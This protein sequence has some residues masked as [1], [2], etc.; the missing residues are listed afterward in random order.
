MTTDAAPQP[1]EG[2]WKQRQ[3]NA[4]AGGT[5]DGPETLPKQGT[6]AAARGAG[7]AARE[8]L[9][10]GPFKTQAGVTAVAQGRTTGGWGR[11]E[12]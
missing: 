9:D 5:K 11:W 8:A 2:E 10:A 1:A 7:G 12:R 6:T 3:A 4:R